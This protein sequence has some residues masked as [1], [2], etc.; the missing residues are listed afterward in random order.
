M[1]L[2]MFEM[3]EQIRSTEYASSVISRAVTRRRQRVFRSAPVVLQAHIAQGT[4]YAQIV[5]DVVGYICYL[6]VIFPDIGY[7]VIR[8]HT[9]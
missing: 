4:L 5:K 2:D 6:D 3:E 1:V 9:V 8:M 7:V